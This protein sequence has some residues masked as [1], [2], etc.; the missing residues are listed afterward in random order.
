MQD[1]WFWAAKLQESFKLGARWEASAVAVLGET[2][3]PTTGSEAAGRIPARCFKAG[4]TTKFGGL[5]ETEVGPSHGCICPPPP[6]PPS[7]LA[8]KRQMDSPMFKLCTVMTAGICR[9][10]AADAYQ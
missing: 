8:C 2:R 5:K 4:F 3:N 7:P 10:W 6:P 1:A 9:G